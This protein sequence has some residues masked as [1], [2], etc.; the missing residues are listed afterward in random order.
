[1][2]YR[3]YNM[4]FREFLQKEDKPEYIIVYP[5]HCKFVFYKNEDK[6]EIWLEWESKRL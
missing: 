1:M 3:T 5:P 6:F 4:T 2:G